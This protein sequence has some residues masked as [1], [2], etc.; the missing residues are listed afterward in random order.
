MSFPWVN[1]ALN[2]QCDLLKFL[3]GSINIQNGSTLNVTIL[4]GQPAP[5]N[6]YQVIQSTTALN[7]FT[8]Q[9]LGGLTVD[10]SDLNIGN[11]QLDQPTS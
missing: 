10:I 1:G 4:G 7:Q 11:Y 6:T 9:T 5:G 2:K 3:S 8:N